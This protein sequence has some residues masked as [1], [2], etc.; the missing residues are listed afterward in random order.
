MIDKLG[1]S[2]FQLSDFVPL[3]KIGSG[4]FSEVLKVRN[5]DDA[6]IYALKKVAMYLYKI[7]MQA[8]K[9]K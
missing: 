1:D 8:L 9:P 7:K 4:S 5:I 3:G 6:K 2:N